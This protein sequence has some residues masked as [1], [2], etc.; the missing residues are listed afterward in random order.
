MAE[1]AL[2]VGGG[3]AG[4]AAAVAL[5]ERGVPVT[6]LESRPRL[7]GRASLFI[8]RASGTQIDNCQHVSLG[9]CTNFQHFCR[10]LG[11]ESFFRTESELFFIGADNTVNRLSAGFLPAPFHC[12]LSFGRMSY[13]SFTDRK[14]IARGLRRLAAAR[15]G[16]SI[17]FADWLKEERQTPAVVD[18]FWTPVLVSALVRRS[19]ALT[20]PR[21]KFLSTLSW[22]A[23]KVGRCRFPLCRST[24]YTASGF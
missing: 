15:G 9:C 20:W 19:T 18:R 23:A 5:S 21:G 24:L 2:I 3:L 6:V 13:L 14:V 7:G 16:D 10:T 12:L 17:S 4:L 1:G 8:D 11:L 22:P